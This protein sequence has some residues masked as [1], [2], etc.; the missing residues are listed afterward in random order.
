MVIKL[1][2]VYHNKE[3]DLFEC[4]SFFSRLKGFMF[5]KN[6]NCCY[7]FSHCNSIH[8][9]FMKENIYV[10]MCDKN[11]TIL[12]YYSNL[13]KNRV[14]MPKSGVSKVFELPTHYFKFKINDKVEIKK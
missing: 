4:K 9:F 6:I 7:Y 13:G 2:L 5:K 14:I 8:T 10:I 12:Y 3:I 11:N 1:K